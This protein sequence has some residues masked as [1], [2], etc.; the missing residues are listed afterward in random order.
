MK[1]DRGKQ[2]K[3]QRWLMFSINLNI[4]LRASHYYNQ[5]LTSFALSCYANHTF[6]SSKLP[7]APELPINTQTIQNVSIR[8]FQ[9][10][11]WK[12]WITVLEISDLN[13][14]LFCCL[15]SYYYIGS[16][17]FKINMHHQLKLR[18]FRDAII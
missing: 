13:S 8:V 10:W 15:N 14:K 2:N 11:K 4:L 16:G 1:L 7:T 9:H 5:N 3:F 12:Q 17:A 6:A 18:F